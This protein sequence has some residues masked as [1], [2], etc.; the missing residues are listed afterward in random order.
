[1]DDV[2][3]AEYVTKGNMCRYTSKVGY[4]DKNYH[5]SRRNKDFAE[6][7][8]RRDALVLAKELTLALV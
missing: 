8:A 2:F 3:I 5:N 1:M 4:L 6:A 7:E